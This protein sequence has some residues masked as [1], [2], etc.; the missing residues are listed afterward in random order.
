[1]TKLR[2]LNKG[3]IEITIDDD[4]SELADL[5][6]Q[7]E[8]LMQIADAE[9]R[10]VA[11]RENLNRRALKDIENN[12]GPIP[13]KFKELFEQHWFDYLC[14]C[15]QYQIKRNQEVANLFQSNYWQGLLLKEI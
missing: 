14:A 12:Y 11:I 15:F 1:L 4:N 6:K 8:M 10:E 7:S 2:K 5:A 9:Q 3:K 13:D